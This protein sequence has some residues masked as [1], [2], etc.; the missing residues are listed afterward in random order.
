MSLCNLGRQFALREE[1]PSSSLPRCQL[2]SL[3][4]SLKD[5]GLGSRFPRATPR[6][7][8]SLPRCHTQKRDKPTKQSSTKLPT[9]PK[10]T[11]VT[12]TALCL[13]VSDWKR[14]VWSLCKVSGQESLSY[15]ALKNCFRV[16]RWCLRCVERFEDLKNIQMC[17]EV[18]GCNLWSY[19]KQ[20]GFKVYGKWLRILSLS[21]LLL[22]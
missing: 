14:K 17:F 11:H 6:S 3:F 2:P 1:A 8:H 22:H 4:P 20:D 9:S 13:V 7:R 16:I 19:K 15:E 10:E 5:S 12:M 18:R 21:M